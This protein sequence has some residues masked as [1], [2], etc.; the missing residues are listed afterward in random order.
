[1]RHEVFYVRNQCIIHIQH[2]SAINGCCCK[3][4]F[5]QLTEVRFVNSVSLQPYVQSEQLIP[6]IIC[7]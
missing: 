1:M 3:S 6:T 2:A 5:N 7:C 4:L